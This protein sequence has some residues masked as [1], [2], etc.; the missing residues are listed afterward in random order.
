M[1]K[2][3]DELIREFAKSMYDMP[4]SLCCSYCTKEKCITDEKGG[5]SHKSCVDCISDFCGRMKKRKV[6]YNSD[7]LR[8]TEQTIK[9][10]NL[11]TI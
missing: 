10:N 9:Y 6:T 11:Y 5:L 7:I 3:N 8:Y 2:T 1:E 4:Q